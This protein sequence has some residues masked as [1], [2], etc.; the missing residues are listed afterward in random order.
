MNRLQHLAQ[1][2]PTIPT[3]MP[4]LIVLACALPPTT[5]YGQLEEI[6]VTAQRREQ[7]LQDVSLAVT[8]I[9]G[10]T[11]D[12]FA[13]QNWDAVELPGVH[14]G[15]G[16][17]NEALYIRGIG[18]GVNTG[19]DQSVPLYSDGT[20]Y[21][22]GR[23]ENMAFLDV[24]RIEVL[25]GPQPIHFGKNAIGG[26]LSLTSR[27]PSDELEGTLEV[28]NEFEHSE[29]IVFGTVGGP[30][31]DSFKARVAVK[32]REMDGWINNVSLNNRQEPQFEDVQG[33]VSAVWE[34]SESVEV[35]AKWEH[36]E[37]KQNGQPNQVYGCSPGV[38]VRNGVDPRVE[39]CLFDEFRSAIIDP[40]QHPDNNFIG[41]E[42]Y[43]EDFELDG[44]QLVIDW[45]LN[46]YQ[47][48]AIAAYYEYDSQL[49]QFDI[50]ATPQPLGTARIGESYDQF[51][52]EFRI[53]SP[54]E[55]RLDWVLG[56]YYDTGDLKDAGI[57]GSV[58]NTLPIPGARVSPDVTSQQATDSWAVFGEIGFQFTDALIARLGGRYDEVEKTIDHVAKLNI[59]FPT[60]FG[61][62]LLP[63][64]AISP[65]PAFA[66][67]ALQENRK[68]T[69]F[70]PS[71]TLEWRPSDGQ[72]F[73]LSWKKGFKAGGYDL[74][75]FFP[76]LSGSLSFDPEE[77]SAYEA[78]ARM[79]FADGAARMNVTAFRSD[80]T[81]LQVAVFNGVIGFN[82]SNA[83]ESRTQGIEFE[84]EWAVSKNLTLNASVT[85]LDANFEDFPGAQ[86][87]ANQPPT[88][89]VV[90]APSPGPGQAPTFA[91]DLSGHPLPFAPDWSGTFGGEWRAPLG[92]E[93]FG[94][95][96]VLVS[97]LHV[98]FTAD[99]FADGDGDPNVLQD[100]FTKIDLRIALADQDGRWELAFIG[101]NLT[102]ELTAHSRL[103]SV[104]MPGAYS[105]LTDR[106]RQL[107]LQA[108]I[109]F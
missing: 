32:Y 90:I 10:Q 65:A 76:P 109:N 71:A 89:C 14:I 45:D 38:L 39:T 2:N 68:D 103:D 105:A 57:Q 54:Q 40:T 58:A 3:L 85:Y 35:Y 81:D 18:T 4:L 17:R 101:R 92:F 93:A 27:R 72:M 1:A 15:S 28:T 75:A 9:S 34:P 51:S 83:A 21:G 41:N 47:L 97:R 31:S 48:S 11:L 94:N 53:L 49:P 77:V 98:F 80:Y 22:R 26:A 61:P 16:M 87:Y 30:L 82:T 79:E 6:I 69:K 102:D 55:E 33:R 70:Q 67:F 108:R 99:Y 36:S 8:A 91:Q 86:C 88:E 20:Y 74:D 106:T 107:G 5:A 64:A 73:Y 66:G 56:L 78:G 84:G 7:N 104:G 24:E 63:A 95:G 59:V 23:A 43:I 44:G 100:G 52:G 13:L 62:I 96:V 46:G 37:I 42:P 25:R 19:F 12:D 29:F 60:P 50:D